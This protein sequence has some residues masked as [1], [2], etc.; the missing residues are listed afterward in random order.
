ME[1]AMNRE[2]FDVSNS[3]LSMRLYDSEL[4]ENIEHDMENY[5]DS[6]SEGK[7]YGSKVDA[8]VD[9]MGVTDEKV[10]PIHRRKD[11]DLL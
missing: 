1:I 11:M 2:G 9:S 8:L 3:E 7:D 5:L 10:S 6:L 4:E